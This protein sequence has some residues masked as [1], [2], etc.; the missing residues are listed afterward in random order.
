M[1]KK[2]LGATLVLLF[3]ALFLTAAG[4]LPT[5][6]HHSSVQEHEPVDATIISTDIRVEEDDDGD[7]TYYPIVN[8]EYAVDGETYRQDNVFPGSFSRGFGSRSDA[9]AVVDQYD[10]GQGVTVQYGP[11]NHGQAYLR[12]DGMP[13]SWWLGLVGAGVALAGGYWLVKTGFRRRK[14]RQLMEDT[15]TEKTQSLSMGPSEIKGTAVTEDRSSIPAPFSTEECV[16]AKYEIKEYEEDNDDDGGGSWRTKES[17]VAHTPFY[18]DDGT[19]SVL[20]RPHDDA[21][22]DLDPDDWSTTYVDSSGRGPPAVQDFVESVDG[23][24]FP[25]NRAGKDNDRKYR[26]NL[27][28]TGESAYIFGTVHPK[29]DPDPSATD[30]DRLVVRKVKNGDPMGEPMYLISDDTEQDLVNRREWALWRLPVGIVFVLGGVA[31]AVGIL[32]PT[33]G[34]TLPVLL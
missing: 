24:G 12:N 20:V 4:I 10:P 6:D 5:L 27:V 2:G 28:R 3:I 29:D 34:V 13:G 15:P 7:K 33:V 17:G 25:S 19:G 22:Y 30:E 8:Y 11:R 21:T 26:Q 16:L 14:Q 23:L 31:M 32:G 18:V 1:D 9:E